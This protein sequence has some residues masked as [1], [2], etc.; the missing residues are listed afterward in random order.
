MGVK[1]PKL[2][3]EKKLLEKSYFEDCFHFDGFRPCAPFKVC[4]SCPDYK[5][6]EKEILYIHTGALGDVVR[7]LSLLEFILEKN[8]SGRVTVLTSQMA[9]KLFFAIK[10]KF[11]HQLR[12]LVM[13]KSSPYLWK[14]MTFD[15]LYNLDRTKESSSLAELIKAKE[16]F[17]FKLNT[18]GTIG[19]YHLKINRAYHLG[20]NDDEKFYQNKYTA[21]QIMAESLGLVKKA[22]DFQRPYALKLTKESQLKV[23][24]LKNLWGGLDRLILGINVGVSATLPY[25]ELALHA[26]KKMLQ[27]VIDRVSF[28]LSI[29]LLGGK[30]EEEKMAEI[31]GYLDR[32][33]GD[34]P[35]IKII[36]KAQRAD[37]LEGLAEV[38]A[39]DVLFTGDTFALHVALSLEVS[40]VGW[41]GPTHPEEIKST[42]TSTFIRS[43]LG[44]SPCWKPQCPELSKCH[45][46]SDLVAKIEEEIMKKLN[47][48]RE[49]RGLTSDQSPVFAKEKIN[50]QKVSYLL[51]E[52]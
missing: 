24:G 48:L 5:K 45:E 22:S 3:E 41:F 14:V 19:A 10:E 42:S 18:N 27:Q 7:Q 33:L 16:K 38:A 15:V 26:Q 8:P 13:E 4:D 20:L 35:F 2:K 40:T 6:I 49:K 12:V 30:K 39:C 23:S 29:V 47:T 46:S 9:S 34:N 31:K 21:D 28:P 36:L 25:K 11:T 1:P 32:S 52:S 37:L 50:T 43:E 17:G 44:C 51:E